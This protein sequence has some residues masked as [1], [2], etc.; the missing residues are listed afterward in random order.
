MPKF[1]SMCNIF[2]CQGARNQL[3]W[4]FSLVSVF[5]MNLWM[6]KL[7]WEYGIFKKA[8]ESK[9]KTDI[10]SD[11]MGT[12]HPWETLWSILEAQKVV[13][14]TVCWFSLFWES[15]NLVKG[16]V[17]LRFQL[18][19]EFLFSWSSWHMVSELRLSGWPQMLLHLI[20]VW[21]ALQTQ[22]QGSQKSKGAGL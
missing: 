12:I 8:V 10:Y 19:S 20:S 16:R 7:T 9:R 15:W 1:W 5:I 4:Y 21:P 11:K 13:C 14:P 3:Y 2:F 18:F 22:S 6:C 17:I